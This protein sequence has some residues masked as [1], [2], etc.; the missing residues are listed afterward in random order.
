MYIFLDDERV[1][2]HVKWIT[3][4]AIPP[5][6]WTIVRSFDEFKM[7]ID[8]LDDCPEFVTFDHDLADE[9]YKV[10]QA[11][12]KH[13]FFKNDNQD[14][15]NFTF[16]YGKEKTGYECAKYF[17]EVAINKGWKIPE[18]TVHSL[19]PVGRERIQQYLA[20]ARDKLNG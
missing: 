13:T 20:S 11:E 7:L 3:L 2:S 12:V 4:P 1:P 8:S 19:N 6:N 15:M 5:S 9:H 10:M 18:Y 14:G 17:V 16:D